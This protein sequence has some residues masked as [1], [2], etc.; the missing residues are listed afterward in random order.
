MA[1]YLRRRLLDVAQLRLSLV[2]GTILS[3]PTHERSVAVRLL[4]WYMRLQIGEYV[5][6]VAFG[7]Q[8]ERTGPGAGFSRQVSKSE[9]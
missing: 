4:A 9:F 2:P 8:C 6:I 1:L 7:M 5:D 3:H